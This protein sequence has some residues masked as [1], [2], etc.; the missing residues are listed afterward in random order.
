MRSL[1][2]HQDPDLADVFV[3]R[4]G[5]DLQD[6]SCPIEVR[7]L[8]RTLTRWKVRSPRGIEHT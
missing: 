2:E 1:Y 3:E 6:A 8:D 5:H 7:A 4:L